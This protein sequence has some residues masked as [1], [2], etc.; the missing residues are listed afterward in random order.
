MNLQ[1]T[2]V[3]EQMHQPRRNMVNME[4][5]IG[6]LE[7][8]DRITGIMDHEMEAIQAY[9][10]S[11]RQTVRGINFHVA[12]VRNDVGNISVNMDIMNTEVQSM[13][14]EMHRMAKPARTINKVLP[15]P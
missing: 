10:T 7:D 12:K 1:F 15:F 9:M 13:F 5:R 14:V 6:L 8:I 4:K 11:M 2:S 3:A